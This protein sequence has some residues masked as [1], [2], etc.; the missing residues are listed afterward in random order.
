MD[1]CTPERSLGT[2]LD[3]PVL[4][5]MARRR[6]PATT[7]D[8]AEAT[9]AT[10]AGV[11]HVLDRLA[12]HGLVHSED[13][14]RIRAYSLNQEHVL[15]G[16]LQAVIEAPAVLRRRITGTVAAWRVPAL[17]VVLFGSW[18]RGEAHATSDVDL[19]VLHPPLRE[20]Q[21][22]IWEAQVADLAADIRR[23]S[24]ND[25]DLLTFDPEDWREHR[26]RR[27]PL[28]AEVDRDAIVLVGRRSLLAAGR[29]PA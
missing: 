7:R 27:D 4:T 23:W 25:V 13:V 6:G 15:A 22:D 29:V 2:S 20:D 11:R 10:V 18:A 14:G 1:L 9:G 28:V 12:T 3:L 24:G 8:V 19:L 26:A 17:L 16:A 5:A 21:I